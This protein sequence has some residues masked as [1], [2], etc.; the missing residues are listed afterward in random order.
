[1]FALNHAACTGAAEDLFSLS[2]ATDYFMTFKKFD[3][4]IWDL[5]NFSY[6]FHLDAKILNKT[7]I[8]FTILKLVAENFKGQGFKFPWILNRKDAV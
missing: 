7:G 1:M 2:F 8:H 6:L 3:R 4:Q 5:L